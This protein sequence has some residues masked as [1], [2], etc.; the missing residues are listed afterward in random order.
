[1]KKLE[2]VEKELRQKGVEE[3]DI[4]F[5]LSHLEELGQAMEM[6]RDGKGIE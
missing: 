2:I 5:C 3:E 1:M 4:E 6:V